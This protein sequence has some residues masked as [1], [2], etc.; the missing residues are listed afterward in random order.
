MNPSK[1]VLMKEPVIKKLYSLYSK[2]HQSGGGKLKGRG[3]WDNFNKFLKDSKII[4]TVGKV[5]L[6][7]AGAALAGLVTAN[8]LA[9]GAAGAVGS[10]GANWIASQ[11]YGQKGGSGRVAVQGVSSVP[12]NGP[13]FKT[14]L[15]LKPHQLRYG[16]N[17][18]LKG[19]GGIQ[20]QHISSDFGQIKV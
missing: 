6:P 15:G 5:V 1:A 12:T 9:A 14:P 2:L 13:A 8:P 17:S 10:A 18:R 20:H 11:G 16:G 4:S 7:A 3:L 19:F